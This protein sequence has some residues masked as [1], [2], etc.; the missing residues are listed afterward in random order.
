MKK[1]PYRLPEGIEPVN[2]ELKLEPNLEEFTFNGYL[3]IIL[4]VLKPTKKI[5]LH[6]AE[7]NIDLKKHVVTCDGELVKEISFNNK[8]ETLSIELLN[9]IETGR[10]KL[11]IEY[12]GALNDNMH[13]FYRT[14]YQIDG[15]TYFG[16][17][18]QFEATDARRCFPCWDEPSKKSTFGVSLIIPGDLTA[19]SNMPI[20]NE[21]YL[22]DGLKLVTFER[23]PKISTYLVCFVIAHLKSIES[24]DKNGVTHR[25]W[26]IPGKEEHGRFAL[27]CS[28]AS[29][30]FYERMFGISYKSIAPKLDMIAC[31]DFA[32]GAME[33]LGAVTYRETAALIDPENRTAA[34]ENR[35]AEVVMHENAHM[36][37][38]DLVTMKWWNGLWLNE[39]FA[40]FMSYCAMHDKFPTWDV[41]T[42]YV[43]GPFLSALRVDSLKNTHPIE[44]DVKNPYEIREIFDEVTYSKGSVVNRMLEQYLGDKYWEGLANYLKKYSYG[45]ADTVYLWEE[46]EKVS[47]KPVRDIM[48]RY[49]KQPGYPVIKVS[50]PAGTIDSGGYAELKLEQ[51]RF[52]ANGRKDNKNLL[53]K[54]PVNFMSRGMT[55][56]CKDSLL[57]KGKTGKIKVPTA[58]SLTFIKL[59]AGQSGFYRAAYSEELWNGLVSAVKH[60]ELSDIERIGLLDDSMELARAG[61]MKTDQALE[62]MSAHRRDKGLSY[63]PWS[64]IIGNLYALD[65]IL[66]DAGK[67]NLA[68]FAKTLLTPV[69]YKLDWEKLPDEKS[70]DTFLRNA[71]LGCLGHFGHKFVISEAKKRFREIKT[72]NADIDPNLKSVIYNLTAEYGGTDDFDALIELYDATTDA[73][74]KERIQ[75]SIACFRSEI[76]INRA[77]SFSLSDK[78]RKQDWFRVMVMLGR[79]EKARLIAWN[80]L[81]EN[82]DDFHKK[83]EG[84]LTLLVRTLEGV[85]SGF[86]DNENLADIKKFFK[87]HPLK[88][89]KRTMKQVVESIETNIK[90]KTRDMEQIKAWLARG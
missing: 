30:E 54:V 39:G 79:N 53:W 21:C 70:T 87:A 47:G 37:F 52:F 60:S 8:M 19:V 6:A 66:D 82:W 44:I 32:S 89:A 17:A 23:S 14:S 81:K 33:N 56:I 28:I 26:A 71:V 90:W 41:W 7:L 15:K 49:T 35:V 63:G 45:N 36:W 57:L 59:N 48:A 64:V 58:G 24:K 2:Y 34:A 3:S 85:T 27:D 51:E 20:R 65:H 10:H 78:V 50:N 25:V 22:N 76:L 61:Y 68:A 55:G 88:E 80:F 12:E 69:Y 11:S 72:K 75:V 5:V 62:M 86:T 77:I 9:T 13:G 42:Q 73:R 84:N 16:A 40:T 83:Y 43:T 67:E 1:N 46:L 31:P 38:G 18:T 4:N 29:V 74:E